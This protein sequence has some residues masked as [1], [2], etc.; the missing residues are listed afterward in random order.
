MLQQQPHPAFSSTKHLRGIRRLPYQR[1]LARDEGGP[2]GTGRPGV[3]L[4]GDDANGSGG[5]YADDGA[6]N[7]QSRPRPSA[8]TAMRIYGNSDSAEI[9]VPVNTA[10]IDGVRKVPT[11]A[12]PPSFAITP[13]TSEGGTTVQPAER[14]VRPQ[15]RQRINVSAPPNQSDACRL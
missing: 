14:E 10:H 6:G 15:P 12:V 13:D 1:Y 8:P 3:L 11:A 2:S 7:A 9:L 5:S 4:F